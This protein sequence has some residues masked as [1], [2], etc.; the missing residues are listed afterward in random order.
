MAQQRRRISG[1]RR[2]LLDKSIEAYI[3]ALETINRLSITYRVEA[4]TFLVCNAWELLL[5]AKMIDDAGG[6][7]RVIYDSKARGPMRPSRSLEYCLRQVFPDDRDPTRRNLELV[8][9]LRN[10]STHLVIGRV[11]K[12]VLGLFQACV[13]N[14]HHRL[15]AW[16]GMSLSRRVNV[17]MM[18][19]VYDFDPAQFD[20]SSRRLRRQLGADTARYLAHFQAQV[21]EQF[22][23]FGHAPEFYLGITYK[24]ALTQKP[25][26][27]D[28][29]L[30]RGEMGEPTGIVKVAR[31]PGDSHPY[32]QIDVVARVNEALRG[33]TVI[34]RHDIQCAIA[35]YNVKKRDDFYYKG[36]VAG[37]PVQYSQRFVD[38][39]ISQYQRDA[40]FF[41]KTRQRAKAQPQGAVVRRGTSMPELA[42]VDVADSAPELAAISV[43]IGPKGQVQ[44]DVHGGA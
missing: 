29:V 35:I 9:E 11:P 28:I 43:S 4:F 13:V 15:D 17:G 3:L 33:Q 23:S 38:W 34:N 8:K 25:G 21:E 12:D 5:K 1:L 14:Y 37:S 2:R 31:D 27:G 42:R 22:S 39:L 20:L 16:F 10:A 44:A 40:N 24:L 36:K 7:T 6:V 30:T 41:A 32:R 19:I 26:E 18:A